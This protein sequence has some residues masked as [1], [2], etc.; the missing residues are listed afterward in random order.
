MT[1]P[2]LAAE[3]VVGFLLVLARVGP[4][5]LLAP[6]FSARA[7]PAQAKVVVASG[8]ALALTP[9]ATAGH[10]LPTEGLEA[11]ALGVKEA[12]VGLAFAFA[13][14]AIV[15]AAQF[16]AGL[17]DT[18][19]GFSY[20]SV[21]DPFTNVQ[22]GILGQLYAIFIAV[23]LIVTGGDQLMIEG[24]AGTF[25]VVPIGE[26]PSWDV[27]GQ[28]A[29]DGFAR[30]FVLGLEVVAPVLIALIVVDCALALVARAAPQLN[31]FAVGLPAKIVIAIMVMV[32][33]LPFVGDHVRGQLEVA[34]EET[35]LTLAG[36]G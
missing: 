31:I 25:R 26:M 21:I 8:L 19:V 13:L 18:V 29:I 14:S 7:L 16:G 24:L 15:A 20:A 1:L 9:I 3:Q 27:F 23:V 6:V 10:R 2:E 22:G 12:L 36:R 30:V 17:V 35:L 34:V 4:L 5:F 28:I 11:V 33:S 32:A